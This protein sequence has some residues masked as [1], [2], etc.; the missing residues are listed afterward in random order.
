MLMLYYAASLSFLK[1]T[2]A[3]NSTTHLLGVNRVV[4]DSLAHRLGIKD[5]FE[6]SQVL[7]RYSEIIIQCFVGPSI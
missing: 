1:L 3:K 4:F 7:E 5:A 2:K 6:A